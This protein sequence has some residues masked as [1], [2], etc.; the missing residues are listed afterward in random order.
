MFS[1]SSCTCSTASTSSKSGKNVVFRSYLV[2]KFLSLDDS[3]L[4]MLFFLI[5]T[6]DILDNIERIPAKREE[7]INFIYSLQ[8]F[9]SDLENDEKVQL[10]G[11][12]GGFVMGYKPENS[13]IEN[14]ES[15]H[16]TKE[17]AHIVHTYCAIL[18]LIILDDDLTR[19]RKD[20]LLKA[21]TFL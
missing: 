2:R 10:C 3:K 11:F 15:E 17:R 21:I 4:M 5:G 18:I 20:C 9:T 7:I 12:K 14:E 1:P 16:F 19:L 8:I 13:K 6:L